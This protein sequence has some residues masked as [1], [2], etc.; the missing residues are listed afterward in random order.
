M[1]VARIHLTRS[2]RSVPGIQACVNAAF[3]QEIRYDTAK[4]QP[5]YVPLER[6]REPIGGQ[7]CVV[8]VPAPEPYNI[9]NV[10]KGR[11]DKCL[12]DA[13]VAF[14]DWLVN[15]SGWKVA[16]PESPERIVPVE[17]KHVCLLF[18]RFIKLWRGHDARLCA[19]PGSA[20][21]S[22]HADRFEIVPQ[23]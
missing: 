22:A 23:A 12:P 9:R 17:P 1:G 4:G 13:L 7:A 11:I 20:W 18:R 6:H 5:A 3:D 21:H 8:V 14:V 2:R 19:Q 10:T 16:D 15:Q